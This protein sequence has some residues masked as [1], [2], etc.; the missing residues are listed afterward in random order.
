MVGTGGNG[1]PQG[2]SGTIPGAGSSSIGG[3][4]G[5]AGGT[6]TAG[7]GG[8]TA[9]MCSTDPNLVNATGC[10]V[11]CD[12]TLTTDNPQGLQG[13]LYTF[14]DGSSCTPV[15]PPCSATGVCLSGATVV[16]MTY[17]KWGCGMGLELNATGG[18]ASVKQA[19][20]GPAQCFKYTL[21]GNSGGNEVRIA[22]TQTADTTGKVS[23][24]VSLKPFTNG[25][26]GTIC[27]KDVSC[28]GQMNC[29]LTGSVYD[30]QVNV[31]GGNNA[32]SYNVCLT[33]LEPVTSGTSTLTQL[34]GAQGS[35][36]GT[37]DVGKYFAQ[38]NVNA[39][40]GSLCL[41]PA[42]SGTN[43]SFTVD[44]AA[45][46]GSGLAAYPSLVDGWHYGRKS[47]DSALPKLVSGLSNVTTSVAYTNPNGG[48]WDA[49]FDIWVLPNNSNPADP[50]GGLEVMLW[51]NDSNVNPAGNNT[52]NPYMGWE[53]W[54][55]QVSSWKYVAYRKTGQ[56]TFSGD[57]APFIKNAVSV[58]GLGGTP[59]LAGVEFG[60]EA[61]DNAVQGMH[62]TSYSVNVQ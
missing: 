35:S 10:F 16:D 17:A 32:G 25:A 8:G 20:A 7:S 27:Q 59:Y 14:G 4:T 3:T 30:L 60:Y 58:A 29:A 44:S 48:T 18:T 23:P 33:D 15:N 2:G 1:S 34:C 46:T 19:Y 40:H 39:G 21:T 50:S 6:G 55:G 9:A 49:S 57:L 28:Q 31:V 36:N 41:T 62:V 42:L 37:E 22:F 43:A 38:N 61:Y 53:V 51:L 45:L 12:P 13:A 5:T 54:S 47:T 26:S 52:N 24:Y 11:G 56:S